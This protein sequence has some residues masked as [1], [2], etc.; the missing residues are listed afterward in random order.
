MAYLISKIIKEDSIPAFCLLLGKEDYLKRQF[1]SMLSDRIVPDKDPMNFSEFS[2]EG[3]RAEELRN[4]LSEIESISQ[5]LPFFGERRLIL[6]EN[7][8]FFK[9]SP[10]G[11][12]DILKNASPTSFFIFRE[13]SVDKRT[14]P[15]KYLKE[16]GFIESYDLPP[17][18]EL[19]AWISQ[20]AKGMG[21]SFDSDAL[22]EFLNR[23]AH[24]RAEIYRFNKDGKGAYKN[25]EV[26]ALMDNI[27]N[28]LLKLLSYCQGDSTIS[29]KKVTEIT[30]PLQD[31]MIFNIINAIEKRDQKTAL[32]EYATLYS[33]KTSPRFILK[34]ISNQFMG[35]LS[36]CQGLKSGMSEIELAKTLGI[37]PKFALQ[38]R[39]ESA[40]R[41]GEASLIRII[42]NAAETLRKI[43]TGLLDE[44]TGV[45]IF[46]LKCIKT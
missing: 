37:D 23:T 29:L 16:H 17:E 33:L 38:K 42:E 7:T 39:I 46:I 31:E 1:A 43:N 13:K 30:T 41:F 5:T 32:R 27:N 8:G 19:R 21:L 25:K 2:G 45:E 22:A 26:P 9:D 4:I 24:D 14:A 20:K 6:C 10:E 35:I 44:R 36:V 40:R 11:F 15:Y 28:E 18:S 34:M 3:K 12:I